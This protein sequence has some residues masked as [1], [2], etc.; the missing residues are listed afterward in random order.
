MVTSEIY[1]EIEDKHF[2]DLRLVGPTGP[3]EQLWLRPGPETS[4][5]E[6]PAGTWERWELQLLYLKWEEPKRHR[7]NT[8]LPGFTVFQLLI[9][10][11]QLNLN[12]RPVCVSMK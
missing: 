7:W 9:K 6:K 8:L 2:V 5:G 12:Q 3:G 1:L 4:Q 10:V 11:D